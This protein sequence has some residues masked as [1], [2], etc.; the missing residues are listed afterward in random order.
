M[1]RKFWQGKNQNWQNR[2]S[3]ERVNYLDTRV[4]TKRGLKVGTCQR[5]SSRNKLPSWMPPNET[6]TLYNVEYTTW[7]ESKLNKT[8]KLQGIHLAKQIKTS[9]NPR[10]CGIRDMIWGPSQTEMQTARNTCRKRNKTRGYPLRCGMHHIVWGQ[11]PTEL[12]TA[13]YTLEKQLKPRSY[14][15]HCGILTEL[16]IQGIHLKIMFYLKTFV[17]IWNTERPRS[18]FFEKSQ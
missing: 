7:F 15:L 11:S 10:Q 2:N 1:V 16:Q 6:I 18:I 3:N 9:S 17:M 5:W 8:D 12:Q 14:P 4:S 13:R